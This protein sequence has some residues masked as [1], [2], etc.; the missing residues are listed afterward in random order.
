MN[1]ASF[2]DFA[3]MLL[4]EQGPLLHSLSKFV[5]PSLL[6]LATYS[7]EGDTMYPIECIDL[8]CLCSIPKGL[9]NPSKCP[10]VEHDD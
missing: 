7:L 5:E 2:N 8:S 6:A 1:E 4:R 9:L 10:L 3:E